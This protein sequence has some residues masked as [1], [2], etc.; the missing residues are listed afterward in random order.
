MADINTSSF[1]E[2]AGSNNS[3]PPDGAPEGMSYASVNNVMREIM[4]AVKREYNRS[5]P[6]VTSGGTSTALTL[7]YTTAPTAYS[8]GLTFS[9][10]LGTTIGNNPTLNVSSLGAKKI[11]VPTSAGPAQP[12]SGTL[13]AGN[14]IV[15]SYVTSLDGGAG[16]FLVTN[17]TTNVSSF[18]ATVLD[19]ADAAT[20]RTTLGAMASSPTANITISKEAPEFRAS[21]TS[22]SASGGINVDSTVAG[23]VFIGS[24]S[25]TAVNFGT[26]NASR[27]NM[28]SGGDVSITGALNV[29]GA[30]T[31]N[32]NVVPHVGL[33]A[34]AVGTLV[35]AKSAG[36]T[37]YNYGDT[38]AGSDLTVGNAAAQTP[39]G[40]V[41]LSGTWRCLGQSQ[42][43]LAW[44]SIFI[45]IS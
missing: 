16:G 42:G 9:F 12:S 22:T 1:S 36:S 10:I 13:V 34:G 21:D 29:T 14:I 3:A 25:N 37:I 30:L 31:A 43:S 6:T 39:A 17:E 45:R 27:I 24:F 41:A 33:S 23:Q 11:Y 40:A 44:P 4:G 19:D 32:T 2:T 28:T 15:A 5:H 18:M 26:N 38:I 7:T 8:A 20:A 35:L